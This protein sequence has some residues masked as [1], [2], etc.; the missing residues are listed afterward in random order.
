MKTPLLHEFLQN[1]MTGPEIETRSFAIID[2]ES[3]ARAGFPED[4]WEIVR[5]LIH[6]TGDE[7]LAPLV[8]ISSNAISSGIDALKKGV[9]IYADSNMIRSGLSVAR[10]REV[11][12]GYDREKI[13]CHVADKDVAELAVGKGVP[14]S[15]LAIRKA[16]ESLHGGIVVFGNAPVALLELN[17]MIVEEGIRPALVIAM[18][19]G[20][21]HVVESKEELMSL[22]IPFIAVTGRRGGSPLA[23][24]ALHAI[25]T[26]ASAP[27]PQSEQRQATLAPPP[28]PEENSISEKDR[29]AFYHVLHTRRDV[30]AEFTGA[31]IP[32]EKLR[33]IL[34][35]AHAAPSVGFMQPW[36]FII[37]RDREIRARL[38]EGFQAVRERE[39]LKF[40]GEKR[41]AYL[42]LKLQGILECSLCILVTFDPSRHGPVVLGTS[43]QNDMDRFSCVCAIQ[44]LWLAARAENI[45]L[46]W[47]SL[48]DPCLLRSEIGLP[49]P[50]EPIAL[51]CLGPVEKFQPRPDLERAGW[52]SRLPLD[53]VVHEG[54][55]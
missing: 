29:D 38:L 7:S 9:S 14:R 15:L 37:I 25:C 22:G 45:G 40:E 36:D 28:S 41:E 16:R 32:D 12:P 39:A 51:L 2:S 3:P 5:R 46:G 53:Q 48:V 24:A 34:E 49:E 21:V 43:A 54:R 10:L 11:F 23:V 42:R 17:R 31:P 30:R 8:H 27:L 52:L 33:R 19:V 35:A 47:V 1:P 13:L 26:R 55:W 6:T 18:P 44:N 20:F 4:Q 50:I